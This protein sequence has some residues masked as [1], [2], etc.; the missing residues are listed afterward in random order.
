MAPVGGRRAREAPAML[1]GGWRPE[2]DEALR[3]LVAEYGEGNWSAIS[4]ALNQMVPP[5]P[6][7]DRTL[8]R[9]GKQ[10]RER[11]NHHL[12]PN[13]TKT[14]WTPEEEAMMVDA[15]RRYG[16]RW[17]E[18]A[19][20]LPGRTE[21]A[22]KNFWN[23]TLRRKDTPRSNRSCASGIGAILRAYMAELGL[24]RPGSTTPGLPGMPG[25][26]GLPAAPAGAWNDWPNAAAAD[27]AV[28]EGDYD[29]D[30]PEEAA[31]EDAVAAGAA[32]AALA[33]G[34]LPVMGLPY[35]PATAAAPPATTAA[36]RSKRRSRDGDDDGSESD[37]TPSHS[38]SLRG[39]GGGSGFT[40]AA[41]THAHAAQAS[42]AL[43][44]RSPLSV[45]G[46]GSVADS[47][48]SSG[49]ANAG[50]KRPRTALQLA[51]LE[52]PARP[53]CSPAP[54]MSGA[55]TPLSIRTGSPSH[56][57]ASVGGGGG[58]PTVPRAA[59]GDA[60]EGAASVAAFGASLGSLLGV[61]PQFAAM[62][63]AVA[64][65]GMSFW[66]PG[67]AVA[68][69]HLPQHG[70]RTAVPGLPALLPH[71]PTPALSQHQQHQQLLAQAMLMHHGL[72]PPPPPA[73]QHPST[74]RPT[75]R[76]GAATAPAG[77]RTSEATAASNTQR[78]HHSDD[79][80][81]ETVS[82][83]QVAELMLMLR[84]APPANA[85]NRSSVAGARHA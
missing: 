62:T 73:Q 76:L 85:A 47:G 68:L 31:D 78:Q 28:D 2:E 15:H 11:W 49:G 39:G 70:G 43:Q 60:A 21:N 84:D 72:A 35:L 36:A 40:H 25:R 52:A 14:A 5:P 38:S 3:M 26:P 27:I 29:G 83:A 37:W 58:S 77:K 54:S 79:E 80:G 6:S 20:L 51:G 9:V 82:E 45:G 50:A 75:S 46:G 18:I 22:L 74:S 55:N 30:F 67:G 44:R 61:P 1:K 12:R 33:A 42:A 65:M 8:G 10:C 23:A 64:A 81:D 48:V 69:G 71:Q 19:K 34:G 24:V 59:G 17:S 66:G 41:H 13:I 16:N 32:M 57:G 63:A 7:G 56:G 53:E 4:R